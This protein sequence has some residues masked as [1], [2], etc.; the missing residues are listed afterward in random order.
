M[1]CRVG[2][3]IIYACVVPTVKH[4][5]GGVMVWAALLVTLFDLFRIH[6]T[7]SPQS[8]DRNPIEMGCDELDQ[9][10][11][12]KQPTSAWQGSLV[13]RGLD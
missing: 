5:G 1:R 12:N 4:G 8:P 10:V 3:Q 9:R 7:W 13:V 2:E 6:M 11:K